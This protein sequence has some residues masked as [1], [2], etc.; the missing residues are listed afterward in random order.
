MSF[1]EFKDIP[2]V[3]KKYGI[4]YR[5]LNFIAAHEFAVSEI[6]STELEFSLKNL[7]AFASEAAR[8]EIIIFPILREAY[9]NYSANLSLWVQKPIS[10]DN[11]LTG[12]P[13]YMVS[14]RSEYG[15][16]FLDHPILTVVEAKKSDFEQGWGQCLAELVASQKLNKSETSVYGIVTDG[17]T[18]KIGYLENKIFTKNIKNFTIDRLA[19]LF[20]ALNF[21]FKEITAKL[22]L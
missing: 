18:W 4:K 21:I 11:E 7:D 22:N 19:E 10:F 5:E 15:K 17:E 16:L 3:Q 20:F 14:K 12:T 9:R 8:C 6:F 13:D 2:Q 1:S